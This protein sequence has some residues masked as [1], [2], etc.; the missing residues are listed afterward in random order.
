MMDIYC[1]AEGA[2]NTETRWLIY[3][4][5]AMISPIVLV[6]GAKW[7]RKGLQHTE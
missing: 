6:L 1:P 2:Q 4:L 7:V 5:V 3:G